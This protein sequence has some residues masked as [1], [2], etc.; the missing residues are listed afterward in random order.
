MKSIKRFSAL[1]SL[2]GLAAL[3]VL[4]YHYLTVLP[5]FWDNTASSSFAIT[6]FKYTPLHIVWAG[7]EAVLFF[8]VLSGFVLSLQF[9]EKKKIHYWDFLM[10]RFFR[11]YIPCY[12]AIFIG[13]LCKIYFY[14]PDVEGFSFIFTSVWD[15]PITVGTI[16]YH[17]ML[18]FY[19]GYGEI[20]LVLWSLVMEIR[21]SLIFPLLMLLLKKYNWRYNLIFGAGLSILYHVIINNGRKELFSIPLDYYYTIT[22]IFM[23]IL[24]ALLAQHKDIFIQLMRKSSCKMKLLLL[25]LGIFLYTIRY[26][27]FDSSSSGIHVVI[28]D[29]SISIGAAIFIILSFSAFASHILKN[30]IIH[31]IG[32]ISYS[33]YLYHA[34]VLFAL[35]YLL[36][37]RLS[38][39]VIWIIAFFG[40]IGISYLSY[41]YIEK[42]SISLGKKLRSSNK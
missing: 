13:I 29:M 8:F 21:I 28:A 7:Y 1:D 37:P 14:R 27:L 32:K 15:S 33:I 36:Y 20:V 38:I 6:A 24:G 16:F 42:P 11:I 35:I 18:L 26:W 31:F 10:S 39:Y 12:I 40:T 41:T 17:I 22:F 23:F 5:F 2:R 25:F 4:I 3:S 19:F 34:T 30:N 9:Y